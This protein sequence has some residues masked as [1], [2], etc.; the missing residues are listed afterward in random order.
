MGPEGGSKSLSRFSVSWRSGGK[1]THSFPNQQCCERISRVFDFI[2]QGD[3]TRVRFALFALDTYSTGTQRCVL[4][5]ASILFFRYDFFR[6]WRA[7]EKQVGR[8]PAAR[9]NH[10]ACVRRLL[11]APVRAE[12][13]LLCSRQSMVV[14]A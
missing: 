6:C 14:P 1:C 10:A 12:V 8:K 2:A 3:T 7:E 5:C 13:Q 11:P 4:V 9:R